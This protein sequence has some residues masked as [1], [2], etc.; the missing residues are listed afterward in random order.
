MRRRP[1]EERKSVQVQGV[2]HLYLAL[3]DQGRL[4]VTAATAV[5]GLSVNLPLGPL[6]GP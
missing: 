4:F 2:Q 1:S 6:A 5:M 3:K